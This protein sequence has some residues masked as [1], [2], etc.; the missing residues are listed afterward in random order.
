MDA[1]QKKQI[2]KRYVKDKSARP[3]DVNLTDEALGPYAAL[4]ALLDCI[5]HDNHGLFDFA[6]LEANTDQWKKFTDIINFA[7]TFTPRSPPTHTKT[8]EPS[9]NFGLH[10]WRNVRDI[11]VC[12]RDDFGQTYTHYSTII[13]VGNEV[14]ADHFVNDF[15]NSRNYC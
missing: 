14:Q 15:S 8:S 10:Y 3:A 1:E 4:D 12:A 2:I 13:P 11:S 9:A 6:T 5:D 7:T